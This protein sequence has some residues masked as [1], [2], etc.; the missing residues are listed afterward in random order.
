LATTLVGGIIGYFGGKEASELAY[1]EA[2]QHNSAN[3]N[4]TKA[5]A[6]ALASGDLIKKNGTFVIANE[7]ARYEFGSG[8]KYSALGDDE[9]VLQDLYNSIGNS[10]DALI[11]FGKQL[12]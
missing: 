5:L 3:E 6:R 8:G 11:E 9:G 12:N 7:E 1:S 10:T 4:Q 2:E